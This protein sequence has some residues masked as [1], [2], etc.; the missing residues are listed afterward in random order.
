MFAT[1]PLKI[2]LT[3]WMFKADTG[4]LCK[5]AFDLVR[6]L[7]NLGHEVVVVTRASTFEPKSC[8]YM[9]RNEQAPVGH[10]SGIQI[11]HLIYG[12]A[13]YPCQWLITKLHHR[14]GFGGFVV[15]LYWLQ[16]RSSAIRNL[17]GCDVIHHVGQSCGLVG[18]AAARA[19]KVLG[20]PFL[21]QPTIHPNQA[22]D[23]SLDLRLFKLANRLLAHT[24]FEENYFRRNGYVQP[25]SVVG[26][27]ISDRCDGIGQRFRS[28]RGI[29][30]PLVLFL[31]RRETNKGYDLALQAWMIAKRQIPTLNFVCIGPPGASS[32]PP[33]QLGLYDLGF[34]DEATK[35]DALAAC[36]C[37][38]VPSL[39]ES[40]GL[41]FMEA[42]RYGKP[43]IAR[44]LPVLVELLG[45]KAALLLGRETA[46]N[47]VE[48]T[49]DEIAAA[50]IRVLTDKEIAEKLGMNLELVS[51]KFL[52]PRV[53]H[54]FIKAY[55]DSLGGWKSGSN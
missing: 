12:R 9:L 7:Q 55:F 42:G 38:C 50:I 45:D 28:R 15:W 52:W 4:G 53:V 48:V 11:K 27:G 37:V 16:A 6:E 25:V 21:I 32:R 3:I 24:K 26:N 29:Q 43:V 13:F 51:G 5:H 23:T 44:R 46:F 34:C 8:E 47:R 2:G 10:L 22:G 33:P 19:A 41:V 14:R 49:A 17:R 31:G 30:G 40:F 18:Y 35:H 39:G 54:K 1:R 36:D 20:V